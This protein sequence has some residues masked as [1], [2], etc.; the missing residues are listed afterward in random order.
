MVF[1]STN[2][3]PNRLKVEQKDIIHIMSHLIKSQKKLRVFRALHGFKSYR[4]VKHGL[5]LGVRSRPDAKCQIVKA[6]QFKISQQS[7][8][9]SLV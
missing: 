6:Y 1:I 5:N 2:S 9:N 4:N 7:S 3:E 8:I